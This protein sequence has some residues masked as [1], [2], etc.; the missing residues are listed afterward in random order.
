M[1]DQTN[2]FVDPQNSTPVVQQQTLET[3][4]QNETVTITPDDLFTNQLAGIKNDEGSQKY[5]SVSEALNGGW[6]FFQRNTRS[7]ILNNA[8]NRWRSSQPILC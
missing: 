6:T 4:V 7:Y 1:S 2:L 5:K 8:D 3:P